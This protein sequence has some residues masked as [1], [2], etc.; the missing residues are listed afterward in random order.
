[1]QKG[2]ST[3]LLKD[4]NQI[5]SNRGKFDACASNMSE[6]CRISSPVIVAGTW[7]HTLSCPGPLPSDLSPKYPSEAGTCR[8]CIV[9]RLSIARLNLCCA[10]ER[11]SS[12][13]LPHR[14]APSS[15]A[16]HSLTMSQI[17]LAAALVGEISSDR[18]RREKGIWE[19]GFSARVM[20]D[21]GHSPARG[22]ECGGN[23]RLCSGRH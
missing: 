7:H 6:K 1:V 11:A 20:G 23:P 22:E 3:T 12:A 17:A 21:K 18:A 13:S 14:W 8:K 16:C 10:F 2:Q 15:A 5:K 9:F 4:R 19:R